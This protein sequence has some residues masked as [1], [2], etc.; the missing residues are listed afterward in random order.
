MGMDYRSLPV[1]T[2][3]S[4]AALALQ[5]GKYPP[6]TM[7]VPN[8]LVYPIQQSYPAIEYPTYAGGAYYGQRGLLP[9]PVV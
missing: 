7:T 9:G 3:Y 8:D 4:A 1:Q 6:T 5:G 2:P